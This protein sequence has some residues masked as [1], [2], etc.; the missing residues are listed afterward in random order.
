[1]ELQYTLEQIALQLKNRRQSTLSTNGQ[2]NA[3]TLIRIFLVDTGAKEACAVNNRQEYDNT[4]KGAE[5]F[6]IAAPFKFPEPKGKE[7]IRK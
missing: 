6:L 5:V 2:L 1:M 7:F 4:R 3:V